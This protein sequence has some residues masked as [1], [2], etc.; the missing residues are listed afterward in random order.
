MNQ[1]INTVNG[2][3]SSQIHG[4]IG[5]NN[6]DEQLLDLIGSCSKSQQERIQLESALAELKDNGVSTEVKT[7]AWQKIRSFLAFAADKAGDVGVSILVKYIE[8]LLKTGG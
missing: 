1:Y 7:T 2:I 3:I 5:Y 4:R 8:T 6:N